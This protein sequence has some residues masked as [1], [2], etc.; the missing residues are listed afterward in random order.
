MPRTRHPGVL[1][2][3]PANSS[4]SAATDHGFPSSSAGPAPYKTPLPPRICSPRLAFIHAGARQAQPSSPSTPPTPYESNHARGPGNHAASLLEPIVAL[5][6]PVPPVARLPHISPLPCL[7]PS[8]PPC[9]RRRWPI[10]LPTIRLTAPS[11]QSPSRSSPLIPVDHWNP[12]SKRI[13]LRF[14]PPTSGRP[15]AT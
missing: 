13:Q 9:G 5:C 12:P 8:F 4:P 14:G 7:A 6:A 2:R 15:L 11:A 3:R 1:A 10:A